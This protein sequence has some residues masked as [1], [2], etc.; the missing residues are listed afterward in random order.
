[1][2]DFHY[3]L[4]VSDS[5]MEAYLTVIPKNDGENRDP[6]DYPSVE[7]IIRYLTSSGI[8]FGINQKAIERMVKHRKTG[9]TIQIARGEKPLPGGGGRVEYYFDTANQG[10]TNSAVEDIT[11]SRMD[12]GQFVRTGQLLA[13]RLPP[14]RGKQ[15]ITVTGKIL[16]GGIGKETYIRAGRNTYFRDDEERELVAA[17]DGTV[18]LQCCAMHVDGTRFIEGDVDESSGDISFPGNVIA[19]RNVTDG[20]RIEAGG[21]IEVHGDVGDAELHAGGGV[22]V[23]GDFTGTGAG[24]IRAGDD[25]KLKKVINQKVEA[26]GSVHVLDF[27]YNTRITAKYCILMKY[28]DGR[29]AG[30]ILSAGW[31]IIVKVLGDKRGT[32]TTA[33]VQFTENPLENIDRLTRELEEI[34][35]QISDIDLQVQVLQTKVTEL[36]RS[37]DRAAK[38]RLLRRRQQ[39][40]MKRLEEVGSTLETL[41][42]RKERL[43]DFGI[44]QVRSRL[45]AGT[46]ISI[47]GARE[48][49]TENQRAVTFRRIGDQIHRDVPKVGVMI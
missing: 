47:N 49:I 9:E 2:R 44:V 12:T 34:H 1:M 45:Y 17:I 35:E 18:S 46:E 38:I 27:A 6:A 23:R 11:G 33:E 14:R 20:R 15:G 30:G 13:R 21:N 31:S 42:M 5:E 7:E 48:M 8:K 32:K 36:G 29:V 16:Q 39:Q 10:N 43:G 41:V 19:L 24:F 25:V 40:A 4:E 22:C 26:G 3:K 28:Y 37:S